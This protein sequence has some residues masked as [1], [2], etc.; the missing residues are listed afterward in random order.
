M[1]TSNNLLRL[2]SIPFE[3]DSQ[4]VLFYSGV[5]LRFSSFMETLGDLRPKSQHTWN[6][7][8]VCVSVCVCALGDSID[9][10]VDGIGT[11]EV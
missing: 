11:F 10:L 1:I 9:F 8:L 2:V 6:F 4:P 5:A 3:V 7:A